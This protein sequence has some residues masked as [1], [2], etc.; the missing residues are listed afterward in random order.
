M[1]GLLCPVG[2]QLS[3]SNPAISFFLYSNPSR[4]GRLV[5]LTIPLRNNPRPVIARRWL[6]ADEAISP[7]LTDREPIKMD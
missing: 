1:V 7:P 5:V 3:L 6:L 4:P 2:N